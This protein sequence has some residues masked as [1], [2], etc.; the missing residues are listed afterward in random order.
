MVV[1][2]GSRAHDEVTT[3]NIGVKMCMQHIL[4]FIYMRDQFLEERATLEKI[5]RWQNRL[6]A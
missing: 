6:L 4:Q 5:Y 1:V 2:V 3:K